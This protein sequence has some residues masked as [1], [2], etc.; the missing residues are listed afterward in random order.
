MPLFHKL[1]E[2]FCF[3]K[4]ISYWLKTVTKRPD[5][6]ILTNWEKTPQT[7]QTYNILSEPPKIKRKKKPSALFPNIL[8]EKSLSVFALVLLKV[9]FL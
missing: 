9:Q 4:I 3:Q 5:L 6:L 2:L 7:P 1:W 8:N